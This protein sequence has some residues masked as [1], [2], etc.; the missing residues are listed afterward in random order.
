MRRSAVEVYANA[1]AEERAI[2]ELEQLMR[3]PNGGHIHGVQLDPLI[4]PLR[5]SPRF[6]KLL[7]E[8]LPKAEGA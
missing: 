5:A 2:T 8:H 4:D 1:G 6:A 3:L 7:A